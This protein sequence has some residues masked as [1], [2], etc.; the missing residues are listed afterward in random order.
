MSV[1]ARLFAAG[2]LSAVAGLEGIHAAPSGFVLEV[3][4][5]NPVGGTGRLYY[6]VGQWYSVHDS[7]AVTM[8]ASTLLQTYRFAIPAQPIKHLRLDPADR[9]AVVNIGRIRLLTLEGQELAAFGPERLVPMHSIVSFSI[10]G[11]VAHVVTAADTPMLFVARP[12]QLETETALGRR[13]V[14]SGQLLAFG[15]LV[16]LL[17]A[18]SVFTAARSLTASSSRARWALGGSFLVVFGA[19]LYWLRHYGHPLP[20]WDEW[21]TDAIDLLIPLKGGF[22]DW[23]ALFIP[24]GEHRI[25]VTRLLN[26]VGTLCNGEWDPRV[27]MTV[28]ALFY[29]ASVSLLCVGALKAGPRLGLIAGLAIAIWS[30]LPFDVQ[31]IYWGDQSQMYAL[32]LLAVCTLAIAVSAKIDSLTWFGACAAGLVGL[33]TMGSGFLAPAVAGVICIARL[34]VA[35]DDR[36]SIG[37]L[38]ALFLALAVIGI[39]LYRDA[40]FQGGAYAR[41]WAQFWPS[42][43]SRSA[44][45]FPAAL[46]WTVFLWIPWLVASFF[47]VYLRRVP[48]LNWFAVGVGALALLNTVGLAHGRPSDQR[49][50]DTK[51]FTAMS[52]VIAASVLSTSAL[53]SRWPAHRVLTGVLLAI[54]LTTV[55]AMEPIAAKG[56]QASREQFGARQ[57]NE[58]L[59][60]AYL[61]TGDAT[62]LRETPYWELPYWNG[63][64][65]ADLLD[66][67]G[68][69]PVLPAEI[70]ASLAQREGSNVHGLQSLGIVTTAVLGLMR[71]GSVLFLVGLS[72]LA[73]LFVFPRHRNDLGS[74]Q[75]R[76]P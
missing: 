52:L 44:W 53:M 7:C 68:L 51:Y 33:F 71:A 24:Q 69:R 45:P 43:I 37:V 47:A 62:P 5:A 57:A 21:E 22:L 72:I 27:G 60:R 26:L 4:A 17:S 1:F 2:L 70:R 38:G 15:F 58:A 16:A 40:P 25:L 14:G 28:G 48:P 42:F 46:G 19:R 20:Y 56:T 29:A 67:P 65:L 66:S 10:A 34:R 73:W 41:T 23:Q 12:L 55:A 75:D 31:N 18:V 61:A 11:G 13:F 63:A 3:E 64:E 54:S 39:C 32:N 59:V 35:K 74:A 6:D 50:F 9:A 8:P 36:L 49:P 76:G 30:C